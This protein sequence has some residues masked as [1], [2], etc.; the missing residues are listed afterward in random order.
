MTNKVYAD[1]KGPTYSYTPNAKLSQRTWARGIV[2]DYS[3]DNWGNLTNTVYSDG[4]PTISLSYDALGRQTEAHDAA[5]ITTFLYGSF[6]SLTNEIVIGVA[7]TNTIERF[8]D[9]FGRDAGYALNYTR[10][11]TLAYDPSTGRLAS[12]QVPSDQSTNPNNQTIEQFSW[13]YLAGSDLKSSLTYP[14]SLTASWTYDANNQLLQVCNATPTNVISQYDYTYDGAGRRIACGKSGIVFTQDDSIAYGYNEKSELTNAVATVDSAY[15]YAYDFDEIGNRETA[16][17]RGSNV[18]YSANALNQYVAVDGFTSQFDDDGNQTLIKTATGV[19]QVTYNAEN[20]PVRWSQGN[21]VITMSFDRM[22]RRV[23][24]NDQRFVYNGYLQIANFELQTS[25]IKLQTFIWDPTEK[26]AARQLVWNCGTTV[27]YYGHDGNK[28]VSE[29]VAVDGDIA[30]YYEYA[31]FGAATVRHGE[32]ADANAWRFSSEFAED[33][34]ATMYYNYRHYEPTMGRW[35]SRDPVGELGHLNI[36]AY[37]KN[38]PASRI[39]IAGMDV[40]IEST[41]RA[42][43]NHERICVDKW[44]ESTEDD[45][46]CCIDGKYYKKDGKFCIAFALR[47]WSWSSFFSSSS[48]SSSSCSSN[49]D[50]TNDKSECSC[51]DG[52]MPDGFCESKSGSGVIYEDDKDD[53]TG[54]V[55]NSSDHKAL[56]SAALAIRELVNNNELSINYDISSSC[57]FD[58]E[59]YKYFKGLI[60]KRINYTVEGDNCRKFARSLDELVS[61]LLDEYNKSLEGN[62]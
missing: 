5:G 11:S 20:R 50:G 16:T 15:R 8:Y 17:E 51:F 56:D 1:G 7:G 21:T 22:G 35:L 45:Y 49:K 46:E 38:N 23:T 12:M 54:K 48:C 25:N 33:D 10:Q 37:A 24:K 53:C 58:L 14:N 57:D 3:Y 47:T 44:V 62:E 32:L 29:V 43:G 13:N 42:N 55:C 19:W 6:G 28:N 60:G 52:R 59:I 41:S 40:W 9:A 27:A 2:T 39:D 26:V 31:P 4:T 18:N 61:K 34:T 36:M 30:A